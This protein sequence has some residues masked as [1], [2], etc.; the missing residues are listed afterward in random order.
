M[1]SRGADA[2][3]QLP[4]TIG[5]LVG[6]KYRID[7]VLG[8]GGMGVVVAATHVDLGQL[9]AIKL[10]LPNAARDRELMARFTREARM[11]AQL[12]G[13]HVARVLDV[14]TD[15]TGVPYLA[16]E[17]LEGTD[18]SRLLR[19]RGPLP[20]AVVADYILQVCEGLAEAHRHGMVHRDIKPAN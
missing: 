10:M 5:S 2:L 17:H 18:L 11:T 12:R 3:A 19:E 13:E 6:G 4:V 8:A 14:G 15:V 7:S 1:S 16:M 9:V 20:A